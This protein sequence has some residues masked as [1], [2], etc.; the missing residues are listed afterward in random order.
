[1]LTRSISTLLL[2]LSPLLLQAEFFMR[3]VPTAE[4]LLRE[5]GG[6][7]IYHTPI[8]VNG[9]AGSLRTFVFDQPSEL[10]VSR[11]AHML[12]IKP[13]RS[14]SALLTA[15]RGKLLSRYLVMRTPQS[16]ASTL[17]T[18]LEQNA[19]SLQPGKSVP[20]WPESIPIFNAT[21]GF[22][23]ECH[24]T[25]TSFLSAVSACRTPSAAIDQ[26][27][28]ALATEGWRATFPSSADFKMMTKKQRV[29]VV[30][31]SENSASGDITINILQRTGSR[32]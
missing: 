7:Q 28:N 20:E 14:S 27:V 30:F 23:A 18:V 2:I 13:P 17:V 1:M 21:P 31:A 29:C 32:E 4:K 25:N 15:T 19:E 16:S 26:A 8:T 6:S 3:T 22:T 10:I 9:S 5:L 24:Q 12:K 11:I